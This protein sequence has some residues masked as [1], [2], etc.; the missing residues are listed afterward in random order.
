ME[1]IILYTIDCPSCKVLEKKLFEKNISF[2]KV[3]DMEELKK[4]N[5]PYFPILKVGEKMLNFREAVTWVN[6]WE[7]NNE[8]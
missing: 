7:E 1:K 4:I 6:E 3:S 8:Y 2:E 5:V